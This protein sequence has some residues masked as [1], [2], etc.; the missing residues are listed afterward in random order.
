[1]KSASNKGILLSFVS[2]NHLMAY[3]GFDWCTCPTTPSIP[4]NQISLGR[5]RSKLVPLAPLLKLNIVPLASTTCEL[6]LLQWLLRDLGI[7]QNVLMW[8]YC[9][10][11]AALHI[12]SN[13]IFQECKKYIKLGCYPIRKKIYDGLIQNC[14]VLLL[15]MFLTS[16]LSLLVNINFIT[17]VASWAFMTFKL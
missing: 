6:I 14:H 15:I 16:S 3:C 11:K 9:D 13:H 8:L 5:P 17:L 7:I 4:K 10:N 2:F 12:T 1:M